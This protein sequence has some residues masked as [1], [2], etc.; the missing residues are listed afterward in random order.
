[1]GADFIMSPNAGTKAVKSFGDFSR[2]SFR[3]GSIH[4]KF[5]TYA[6]RQLCLLLIGGSLSG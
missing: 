4:V 3:L 5:Y 2:L 6:V 1:M